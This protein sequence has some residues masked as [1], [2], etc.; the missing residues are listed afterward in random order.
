MSAEPRPP[1]TAMTHY[2]SSTLVHPSALAGSPTE[3]VR[4]HRAMVVALLELAKPRVTRMVTVTTACGALA[5]PGPTSA[6][7][8]GMTLVG[9]ALVVAAANAL[10]MYWERD[11][12]ALMERT[13]GRPLP[14]GRLP[15]EAALWFA[16]VT[17]SAGTALLALLVS[18]LAALL[19]VVALV[20]YVGL[21][22]PLKRVTPWALQLGAIPGAMPPLIGWASVTGALDAH[23]WSLFALLAIWQLPHFLAIALFRRDDYARAGIAVLPVVRGVPATQRAIVL[24]SAVLVAVS[25]VPWLSG[26]ASSAY[27][28]VALVAGVAFFAW[29]LRGLQVVDERRWARQLFIA[30]LPYLVLVFGSLVA[31]V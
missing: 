28:V 10:N 7:R 8:L 27:G 9:T 15:P 2:P 4:S 16:G 18:P 13:C 1:P 21:Y 11:A 5:A 14:S 31:S 25:M 17:A 30:S 3:A 23:A 29:A 12:D 24:W 22:T 6:L 19:A 26:L 20:L